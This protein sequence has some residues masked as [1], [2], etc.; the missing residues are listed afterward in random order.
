M[1]ITRPRYQFIPSSSSSSIL[2]YQKRL[3][4]KGVPDIPNSNKRNLEIFPYS[5]DLML[6]GGIIGRKGHNAGY[7]QRLNWFYSVLYKA[8]RSWTSP[9]GAI[10]TLNLSRRALTEH[11]VIRRCVFFTVISLDRKE[12]TDYFNTP[13]G[14]TGKVTIS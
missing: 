12:K 6:Y 1:D 11:H 8:V 13:L 7:Y 4:I 5:L 2:F 9:V 14:I 10:K 3:V